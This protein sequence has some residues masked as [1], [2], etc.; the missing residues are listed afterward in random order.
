[1]KKLFNPIFIKTITSILLL[2]LIAKSISVALLWYLPS[3]G[4]SLIEEE[5]YKPAFQRV[6]FKNMID[7]RENKLKKTQLNKQVTLQGSQGIAITRILLKA[8]YGNSSRGYAIVALKSSP[9]KTTIISVGEVYSGYTLK[10]I[11]SSSILFMKLGKRY[12]LEIDTLDKKK[13]V[14]TLSTK[15]VILKTNAKVTSVSKKDIQ[16]YANNPQDIMRDISIVEER[17]GNI[18][19][20]FKVTR[21]KRNSKMQALGIRVND[22][23]IKAN[24]I[25]LKS[26]KDALNLYK[27]IDKLDV[28]QIVVLRNN[29]EKELIYEIN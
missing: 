14:K 25:T 5:N 3:S 21:I 11:L 28:I 9:K 29:Q 12:V 10:S 18:I 6:D 19:K 2:L 15:K 4:I 23:I 1:M 16:H 26:Y 13:Y 7:T 8:L 20:G 24:N 22:V 17:S 27:D